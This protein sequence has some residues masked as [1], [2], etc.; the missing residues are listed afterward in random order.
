MNVVDVTLELLRTMPLPEPGNATDKNARGRVFLIAG[1]AI[2]PG[3]SV[4]AG[5]AALRSGA[6]K[7]LAGIPQTIAAALGAA[8]P[9]FGILGL[10]QTDQGEVDAKDFAKIE[11]RLDHCDAVLLGPGFMDE[12][13]ARSLAIQVLKATDRPI[14]LDAA[15]ITAFRD[16]AVSLRD[17]RC[18]PILTPHAGE[19][20]ALS[21]DFRHETD[22]DLAQIAFTT[23][24][25]FGS[26]VVFKGATT[27]IAHPSGNVW[28]HSGGVAGLA[29]AG[30]GDVLAGL[31]V[32][33]IARGTPAITAC[34]WSVYLHA[35]A[36]AYLARSI[37]S[38][39]FLARQ[40]PAVFPGLLDETGTNRSQIIQD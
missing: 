7:V 3:A 17:A 26:I 28:R 2:S 5:E 32:G 39:G 12:E 40:L 31:L 22:G 9:E 35:R 4:L 25:R 38:L 33:L 20:A 1:S 8:A 29:T 14:I 10:E 36:G 27:H 16:D 13:N 21:G 6:G 19:M 18:M 30:S 15:A 34:L 24:K 37:G 11:R 23:A